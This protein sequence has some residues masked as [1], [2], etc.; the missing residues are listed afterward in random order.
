MGAVSFTFSVSR[1]TDELSQSV[2]QQIIGLDGSL[3]DFYQIQENI[4]RSFA[5]NPKIQNYN[6]FK[7]DTL[8]LFSNT[9]RM[10]EAIT[11]VYFAAEKNGEMIHSSNVSLPKGYKPQERPWY[12]E[13]IEN[14]GKVIWTDPFIDQATDQLIIS[15]ATTVKKGNDVQGVVSLNITLDSFIQLI[16]D[17]QIGEDGYAALLDSKGMVL[18]HPNEEYVNTDYSGSSAYKQIQANESRNDIIHYTDQGDEKIMSYVTNDRTNIILVGTLYKS[19]LIQQ[20]TP[21]LIPIAISLVIV[22]VLSIIV[23][24]MTTRR[25]TKP[26]HQLQANM[27]EVNQGDLRVSLVQDGQNEIAQLS[28]RVQDM[29]EGLRSIIED[30]T[31]TSH[32]LSSQGEELSLSAQEVKSGSEQIASTMQELSSGAETQAHSSSHLTELMDEFGKHIRSADEK[33]SHISSSSK[34]VLAMTKEGSILMNQSVDQMMTIDLIVKE[35]VDKVKGLDQ[36][37]RKINKLV[38]V[39]SDIAEQTNLLSLNAAIE[40]AR[41]G[42]H[43][44]GFAVV[45]DEVRK[46]AEQVSASVGDITS[47]V[48]NIQN[49]SNLVASSLEI[50]YE[51]VDNGSKQIKKTGETFQVIEQSI[52]DMVENIQHISTNLKEIT[53]NS[54]QMNESIEE[55]ASVAEESAAG[56]EQTAASAQQSSSSMEEISSSIHN[57]ANIAQKLT[58]QVEKYRV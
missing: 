37:S 25:L 52:S 14:E 54:Q 24:I 58:E 13:A 27:E 10:S 32:I 51:E 17:V 48:Q 11:S 33:G 45:A 43:G 16:D 41:A 12:T 57:L 15:T 3:D 34:E 36:H 38:D 23:S 39:I 40:A 44:K 31:K 53:E 19:E 8:Q 2:N 22:I 1:T 26:I 18:A 47:I 42:E 9:E 5:D 56:V 28:S 20:A 4:L 35:A 7:M 6:D 46:L 30:V 50:G 49:E 29:K 55:I 21:I